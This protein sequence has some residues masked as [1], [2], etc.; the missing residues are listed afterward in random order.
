[1]K[2]AP[3]KNPE[4]GGKPSPLNSNNGSDNWRCACDGFELVAK[5]DVLAG[6]HKLNTIHI[7][8][9]RRGPFCISLDD[10]RV[11]PLRVKFVAD[12]KND[13]TDDEN[14]Y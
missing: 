11:D 4:Q 9:C 6:G 3:I 1:M 14:K 5:K 2:N 13:K 8:L 12:E 10:V 7:H